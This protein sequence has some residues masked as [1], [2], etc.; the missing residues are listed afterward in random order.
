MQHL[1]GKLRS[2]YEELL[3]NFNVE[4]NHYLCFY[5]DPAGRFWVVDH[6]HTYDYYL[7][8]DSVVTAPNGIHGKV[9]PF[10]LTGDLVIYREES[11]P[12][13]YRETVQYKL[14]LNEGILQ[15]IRF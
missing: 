11:S 9:V 6:S 10:G 13:G 2:S 8:G 7:D 5:L 4:G 14:V 1:D 3:G 15:S 12:D